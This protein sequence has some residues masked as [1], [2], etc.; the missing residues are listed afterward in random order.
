VPLVLAE[1]LVILFVD[2]RALTLREGNLPDHGWVYLC[3]GWEPDL[4]GRQDGAC[5]VLSLAAQREKYSI[6]L[7]AS[8]LHSQSERA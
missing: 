3:A 2:N 8:T 1:T 5:V 6:Y 7:P 4:L